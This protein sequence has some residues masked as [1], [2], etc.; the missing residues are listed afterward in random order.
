MKE[1]T[2]LIMTKLENQWHRWYSPFLMSITLIICSIVTFNNKPLWCHI[3][4]FITVPAMVSLVWFLT[5]RLPLVPKGKVGIALAFTSDNV[6]E[7][8]Q[9]EFDFTVAL[10]KLL[11]RDPTGANFSVVVLPEYVSEKLLN[12]DGCDRIMKKCRAHLLLY[13]TAKKRNVRGKETHVLD[14]EG[15]VRHSPI[16]IQVGSKFATDFRSVIPKKLMFSTEND[17]LVFESASKWFDLSARYIIGVAAYLSGSVEYAEN[18]LLHLESELK[19]A[20]EIPPFIQTIAKKLPTRFHE[21]YTNWH[22]AV[23]QEYFVTGNE[24]FLKFEDGLIDKLLIRD[25]NNYSALLGKS[26]AEFVLRRNTAK[27]KSLVLKCKKSQD[28]TWRYNLAF[29]M[30]Y[31]GDLRGCHE[32]YRKAFKSFTGDVTVP[33]QCEDFIQKIVAEEPDKGQL[34]FALGLI[35]YNTKKDYRSAKKDFG[36][37]IASEWAERSE[38]EKNLCIKLLKRCD[39]W[40]KKK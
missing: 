32:E 6:E 34:H 27:A 12:A 35:N 20:R 23:H 17:A 40:L 2:S 25:P 1:F 7:A 11:Q 3:V 5:T 16:P 37:F 24:E 15:A 31:E 14:F 10:R 30:C 29:L 22:I 8:K 38:N 21:L 9:L 33:I 4:L 36:L 39:E 13:G 18:M 26:V 28:A 19:N